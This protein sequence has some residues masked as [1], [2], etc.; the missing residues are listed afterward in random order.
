[1][2]PFGRRV[3]DVPHAG[4]ERSQSFDVVR[5]LAAHNNPHFGEVRVIVPKVAGPVFHVG[6]VATNDV[7]VRAILANG[8]IAPGAL[9]RMLLLQLVK[10]EKQTIGPAVA[11]Y[12]VGIIAGGLSHRLVFHA[13]FFF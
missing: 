13:F 8:E 10:I 7:R 9:P 3:D 2:P 5:L 11:R 1:M 12:L 4:S 6:A